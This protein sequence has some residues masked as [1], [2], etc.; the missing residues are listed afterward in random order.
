MECLRTSTNW[1]WFAQFL[2][3]PPLHECKERYRRIK[4]RRGHK[5]RSSPC[6][7]CSWP[8]SGMSYPSLNL[9]SGIIPLRNYTTLKRMDASTAYAEGII[10]LRNYTTLK[11]IPVRDDTICGIIPL[12]NY[13]TLKR[14][15]S[16]VLS[17]LWII[18]L[19][20]YTTLKRWKPGEEDLHRIIPLRNYTT[21]K[22]QIHFENRSTYRLSAA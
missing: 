14:Q 9:L 4:S 2:A 10:P 19:R 20:N 8:L 6:A 18:P 13:T 1:N 11:P 21:L 7:G 22:L 17:V 12:R 15:G 16:F 5:K 3:F